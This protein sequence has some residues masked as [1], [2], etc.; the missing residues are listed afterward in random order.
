MRGGTGYIE[1][2]W[3]SLKAVNP[4]NQLLR[5]KLAQLV[6]R[7]EML[8]PRESRIG[9]KLSKAIFIAILHGDASVRF[10]LKGLS[11]AVDLKNQPLR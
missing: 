5:R 3:K 7:Q 2:R 9:V 11:K 10:S 4:R 1:G 8:D 6:A